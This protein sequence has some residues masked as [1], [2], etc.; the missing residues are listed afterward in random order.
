MNWIIR[1]FEELHRTIK[2]GFQRMFRGYDDSAY[3]SLDYY[4]V[5]IALPVLKEYRN[6]VKMGYPAH[7]N[8]PEEWDAIMDKIIDAFQL[9]KDDKVGIFADANYEKVSE[10]LELFGKHFRSLWS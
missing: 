5:E 9:M 2:F 6:G 7:L 10:G 8:S 3:W 1:K 4:L